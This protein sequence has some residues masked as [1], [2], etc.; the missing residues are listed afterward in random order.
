MKARI[1]QLHNTE[2]G[3]EKFLTWVPDAG[4][5]VVYDPDEKISYSRLKIGDGKRTLQELD[6]FLE[7]VIAAV[8]ENVKTIT[9][10]DAGHL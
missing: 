5:L 4:E 9:S 10:L 6:F 8:T 7:E 3:W 2:A 1:S